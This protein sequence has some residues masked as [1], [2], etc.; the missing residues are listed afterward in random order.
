MT[1]T[2]MSDI[3]LPPIAMSQLNWRW[4]TLGVLLVCLVVWA[5]ALMLPAGWGEVQWLMLVLALTLHSSF[6]HEILHGG[7]F[8]KTWANTLLGIFQPGLCVPYL[9]FR[10]LHLAHHREAHL[11]DP[12]DDPESAYLDPAVWSRLPAW[13]QNLLRFNNTL[14]GRMIVGPVIGIGAFLRDDLRRMRRAEWDV[15]WHWLAHLPGVLVTLWLV[16]LST[17]PLWSYVLACFGAMSVLRIRTFLEHRA[18]VQAAGRSVIIEDRGI[19][20]FLFLNNNFHAVHH[21]HPQVA[22]YELPR[23]YQARKDRFVRM[24]RGYVFGSYWQVFALY[25]LR[26]KDPVAHPLWQAPDE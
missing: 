7:L 20:A 19:L 10:A 26:S 9:R 14:L 4:P 21:M 22:W 23:L 2:E 24:N 11:T 16:H 6:S 18:Y 25:F 15:V 1:Q 3:Q 5:G 12:Y 13:Q 8:R 17:V